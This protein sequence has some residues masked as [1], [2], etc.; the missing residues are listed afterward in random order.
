MA[1]LWFTPMTIILPTDNDLLTS[2]DKFKYLKKTYF[3]NLDKTGY[4]IINGRGA[5]HLCS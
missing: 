3:L 4:V 5:V 2:V 1:A